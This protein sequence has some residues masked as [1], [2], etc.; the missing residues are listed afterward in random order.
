MCLPEIRSIVER[1]RGNTAKAVDLLAPVMQYE[2]GTIDI[3][4]ERAQAYLASGE[5]AKAVAEFEKLISHRGWYEWEVFTPLAELGLARAY[6]MQEDRE[7]SRK[8]YEDFFAAWKEADPDIPILRQAIAEYRKLGA[9]TS[10]PTSE[11]AKTQ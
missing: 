11:S 6:A 9:T 5:H 8:A 4:Y 3:P 1:E 2:Q 7:K 10:A